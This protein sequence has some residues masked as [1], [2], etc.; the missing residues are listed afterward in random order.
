MRPMQMAISLA[1]MDITF[2]V[3]IWTYLVME[4][5]F[6]MWATAVAILDFLILPSAMTAKSYNKDYE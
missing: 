5:F 3:W 4:L 1:S 6:Q 2:M